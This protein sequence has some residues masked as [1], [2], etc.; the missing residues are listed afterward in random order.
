MS[1]SEGGMSEALNEVTMTKANGTKKCRYC[2]T[3]SNSP[4]PWNLMGTPLA[5]WHPDVPWGR[6]KQGAVVGSIC[7][8]CV[9]V[10]RFSIIT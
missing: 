3:W 7:K 5:S 4:C 1:E 8:P 6:G 9:I 2:G 10:S